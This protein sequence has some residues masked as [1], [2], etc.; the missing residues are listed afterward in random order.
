MLP[1]T[2]G[3]AMP[4]RNTDPLGAYNFLVE[5]EGLNVASFS[6]VSGLE[7]EIEVIEYRSGG[8]PS[9]LRKLPGLRKY[10]NITLKRGVAQSDDLWQWHKAALDGN[11]ERRSGSIVLLEDSREEAAR[12]NFFEAWPSKYSGP[13]LR[14]T[15]SEVAIELLTLACERI[16]FAD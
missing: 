9:L 16:E 2:R 4:R 3:S 12:W 7:T 15:S 13:V 5:I 14:A 6:E 8:E 11:V 10:G 1:E